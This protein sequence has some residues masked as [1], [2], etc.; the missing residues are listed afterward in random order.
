MNV[1]II[2]MILE[3]YRGFTWDVSIR[4]T[5]NLESTGVKGNSVHKSKRVAWE[6]LLLL[7]IVETYCFHHIHSTKVMMQPFTMFIYV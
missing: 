4:I 6:T 1:F 7:Q 3:V 2:D 5:L